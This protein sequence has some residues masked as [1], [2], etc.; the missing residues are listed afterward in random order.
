MQHIPHFQQLEP[1]PNVEP[2]NELIDKLNQN[3]AEA[4][5]GEGVSAIVTSVNNQSGAVKITANDLGAAPLASPVFTGTPSAPTPSSNDSSTRIATTAFVQG[6]IAGIG[7]GNDSPAQQPG[8]SAQE[9]ETAVKAGEVNGRS[10]RASET[11]HGVMT[12][13]QYRSMLTRASFKS[14][15]SGGESEKIEFR[16]RPGVVSDDEMSIGNMDDTSTGFATQGEVVKYVRAN[17]GGIKEELARQLAYQQMMAVSDMVM[18]VCVYNGLTA[19]WNANPTAGTVGTTSN[20]NPQKAVE[21]LAGHQFT[22]PVSGLY[23][24]WMHNLGG[25]TNSSMCFDQGA[26][27]WNSGPWQGNYINNN[28]YLETMALLQAGK[29]YSSG[30]RSR[31]VTSFATHTIGVALIRQTAPTAP[32]G[33]SEEVVYP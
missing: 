23:R 24:I 27:E 15:V 19:S 1:F 21:F 25:A 22:V 10:I 17:G 26:H 6:L 20:L 8:F 32:A 7:P 2:I 3:F 18:G 4:A 30:F 13:E 12:P 28:G 33:Y 5:G 11:D 14:W 31:E 16:T 29:T 9:F